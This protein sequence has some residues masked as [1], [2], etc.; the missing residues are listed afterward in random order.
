MSDSRRRKMA[1][2]KAR[3]LTGLLEVS[4]AEVLNSLLVE[5]IFQVLKSQCELQDSDIDIRPL[6]EVLSSWESDCQAS[7]RGG[8]GCRE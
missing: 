7:E 6:S 8:G 2:P 5:D 4:Q 3:R 1:G